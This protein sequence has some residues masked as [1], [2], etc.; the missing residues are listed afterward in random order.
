MAN[1][2]FKAS[3]SLFSVNLDLHPDSTEDFS[4][5]AAMEIIRDYLAKKYSLTAQPIIKLSDGQLL[6]LTANEESPNSSLVCVVR[7]YLGKTRLVTIHLEGAGP[8]NTGSLDHESGDFISRKGKP[9]AF[10][11]NGSLSLSLVSL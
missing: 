7:S 6:V 11:T 8:L 10:C 1:S 3:S 4:M 2:N 9:I 5:D